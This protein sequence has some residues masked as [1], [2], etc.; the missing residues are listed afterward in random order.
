MLNV[1]DNLLFQQA[2]ETFNRVVPYLQA[3]EAMRS[4]FTSYGLELVPTL[5][6]SVMYHFMRANSVVFSLFE[7]FAPPSYPSF[8]WP[9]ITGGPAFRKVPQLSDQVQ[10]NYASSPIPSSKIGTGKITFA[11]GSIGAMTI[12]TEQLLWASA[13]DLMEAAALEYVRAAAAE[14]DWVLK[15]GA[16]R[17]AAIADPVVDEVKKIVGF[18]RG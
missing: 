4:D 5:F 8:S 13:P 15:D 9:T 11:A 1:P 7:A 3:D 6:G 14:I 2:Y 16:E 12:F 18:W 17:A 10:L